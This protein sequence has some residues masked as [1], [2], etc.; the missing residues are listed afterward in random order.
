MYAARKSSNELD[1]NDASRTD[2]ETFRIRR[3][4]VQNGIGLKRGRHTTAERTEGD[5]EREA[6][7][8]GVCKRLRHHHHHH[9]GVVYMSRGALKTSEKA[10]SPSETTIPPLVG[11]G[12]GGGGIR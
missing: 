9:K 3:N 6:N 11:G 4:K 5:T 12:G 2:G 7:G 10:R 8:E 1:A